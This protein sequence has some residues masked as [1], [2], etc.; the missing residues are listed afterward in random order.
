MKSVTVPEDHLFTVVQFDF[1]IVPLITNEIL[2]TGFLEYK[3]E[4]IF[5]EYSI[6]KISINGENSLLSNVE[7]THIKI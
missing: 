1:S 5:Q 3:G 7:L 6:R 4:L 2:L